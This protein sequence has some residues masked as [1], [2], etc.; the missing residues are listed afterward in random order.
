MRIGIDVSQ[1]AYGNTGVA[2]Y[3]ANLVCELIKNDEHE[4]VLFF[5]SL[6]RKFET[7]NKFLRNLTGQAN[8][9]VKIKE[10]RLPPLVLDFLWNR[11]HIL[12]IEFF[13]GDIDV[14][15]TSDWTEPPA[16]AAKKATIIY[17]LI[18]YKHAS[19]TDQK[20]VSVQK[21]KL[22]WVK[23][24]SDIVFCISESSKKDAVEILGLDPDKVK[25]IYPGISSFG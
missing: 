3:L 11:L 5:S 13:V 18:V 24:E 9:N 21:R 20:I 17:D 22:D 23:K 25:V 15:I 7:P 4:W 10:F 1:I 2:N 14:F 19:E 12:P 6:R 16:R 8:S